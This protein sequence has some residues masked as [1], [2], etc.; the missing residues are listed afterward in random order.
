MS[1]YSASLHFWHAEPADVRR[2]VTAQQ[3]AGRIVAA[4]DQWLCFVPFDP[5]DE[6]KIIPHSKG[7][8]L[9][10][11]YYDDYA[12]NLEFFYDGERL[13]QASFIWGVELAG[14]PPAAS[15]PPQLASKLRGMGLAASVDQLESLAPEVVT[16]VLASQE[17]RDGAARALGLAAHEWLSPQTCL[18]MPLDE[19]REG[20]PQ[21]EDIDYPA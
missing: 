11:T 6:Q 2:A 17:V 21:A 1:E 3:A 12:L 13:D 5:L 9:K 10:W 19:F 15:V 4:N 18:G 14:H 16:G 7:L 8:V 20:F